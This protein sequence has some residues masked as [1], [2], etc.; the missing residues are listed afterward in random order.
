M[1]SLLSLEAYHSQQLRARG[2]NDREIARRGYRTLPLRGRARIARQLIARFGEAV[3]AQLPGLY[4]DDRYGSRYWN[5]AGA[6]GLVIPARD[7]Q[8]RIVALKIRRDSDDIGSK[9]TTLT[10]ARYN[11]P[12]PGSSAH[13]PLHDRIDYREIRI[14]EGELKADIATALT[15]TLTIGVPGVA[16]WRKA[17]P[18]LATLKLKTVLLAFDADWRTNPYVAM[19]MMTCAM[20][21]HKAGF[22][23]IVEVWDI[24]H[25]KGIDDLLVAGGTPQ[26]KGIAAVYTANMRSAGKH[27]QHSLQDWVNRK[28][29]EGGYSCQPE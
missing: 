15:E 16:M 27:K 22:E 21:I 2:L 14:T 4:I 18:I 8:G 20:A 25:G 17:L 29:Q 12:S 1:L 10:S 3:C 23:L 9:Y 19:A 24:A 26:R 5:L 11:G 28:V 6:S 7:L 13:V